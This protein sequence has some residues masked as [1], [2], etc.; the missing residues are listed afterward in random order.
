MDKAAWERLLSVWAA[1][2]VKRAGVKPAAGPFSGLGF[3]GAAGAELLVAEARLGC[4]LPPSYREVLSCTNGLRQ[5]LQFVAARGGN[6]WA[7]AI[8]WFSVRN[9]EWIDPWTGEACVIRDAR[10]VVV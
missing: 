10:Y 7:E 3:P 6:F 8:D 1:E 9:Q 5:P 4:R 2:A